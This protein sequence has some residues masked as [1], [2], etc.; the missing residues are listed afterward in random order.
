MHLRSSFC[1]DFQLWPWLNIDYWPNVYLMYLI[2]V[3]KGNIQH[4]AELIV[5]KYLMN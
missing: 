5:N 4:R 2:Q 1:D 3:H